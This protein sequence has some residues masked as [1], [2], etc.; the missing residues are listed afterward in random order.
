MRSLLLLFV[1]SS[2]LRI[3]SETD[4]LLLRGIELLQEGKIERALPLLQR[5]ATEHPQSEEAHNYYGFALGKMGARQMAIAEF[6]KALDLNPNY[7]EALYNL[8]ATLS[9]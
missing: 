4:P 3:E 7:P 8:G 9:Q 5:S 6:R 2:F 1:F